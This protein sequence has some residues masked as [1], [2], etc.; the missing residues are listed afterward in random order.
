MSYL[1]AIDPKEVKSRYLP[2]RNAAVNFWARGGGWRFDTLLE[3]EPETIEWIDSLPEGDVL[4]DIG[5]NVGIYAIYAAMKGMKVVAFEPHFANYFQLCI[6]IILN[7]LQERVMPLC[8]ALSSGKSVGTINLASLDFGASMATFGSDLDFRGNPYKPVF[9][10]GMVGC[11]ID[12][13]IADFGMAAPNHLKID[14]DGI[15]LDIV[16]GGEKTF[17]A[18]SV[19]SIS[20]ELIDTDRAQVEGV[21][22]AMKKAGLQFVHKLQ[23]IA[24]A[25]PETRDV[26][27]F[28][29]R[30]DVE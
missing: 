30:R 27:N 18:E 28:L 10:Q 29:Y 4:W 12:S 14:V 13:L 24:F 2:S 6:N 9:R 1:G 3:K 21:G 5:A 22:E 23:N 19:K 8:F 17:A 11:D 7:N 20:I 16:K 26:M 15:E 25:L